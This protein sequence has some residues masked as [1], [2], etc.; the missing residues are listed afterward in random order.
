MWN[1]KTWGTLFFVITGVASLP[2]IIEF[3]RW[4]GAMLG[5]EWQWW[6]YSLLTISIVGLL[7]IWFP[8]LAGRFSGDA[9]AERLEEPPA[10]AKAD[11]KVIFLLR[12]IWFLADDFFYKP[13]P[14]H[15]SFMFREVPWDGPTRYE[16]RPTFVA[17][18]MPLWLMSR[19]IHVLYFSSLFL[20][21]ILILV[22]LIDALFGF[23][24]LGPLFG[25]S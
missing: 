13:R 3:A 20:I 10:E 14:K 4:V 24:L 11:G 6:N 17:L 12:V 5:P 2:V 9:D 21:P 18:L 16:V 8:K 23:R 7:W 1:K 19:S 15:F 22:I 25:A